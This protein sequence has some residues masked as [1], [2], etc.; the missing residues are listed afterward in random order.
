MGM[1]P[2]RDKGHAL[3]RRKFPRGGIPDR[4][5]ITKACALIQITLQPDKPPAHIS[6]WPL[7]RDRAQG[8]P[9]VTRPK[10][11]GKLSRGETSLLHS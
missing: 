7:A 1:A 9:Q 5:G 3:A 4:D 2:P 11:T 8:L 10:G 6:P